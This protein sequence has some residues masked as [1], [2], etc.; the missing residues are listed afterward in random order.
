I[1]QTTGWSAVLT[2][3]PRGVSRILHPEGGVEVALQVRSDRFAARRLDDLPE[4][5]VPDIR[6]LLAG[7]GRWEDVEAP[8][9]REPLRPIV[10]PQ[11]GALRHARCMR[12]QVTNRHGG[13]GAGP[14]LGEEL[15][16]RLIEREATVV[17]QAH[18][19][20]GRRD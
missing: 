1:P 3:E 14:E 18:H 7:A 13:L 20:R 8:G 12:Q 15:A 17:D 10:P 5:D 6:I 11:N 2:I 9:A 19:R 4:E 16:D